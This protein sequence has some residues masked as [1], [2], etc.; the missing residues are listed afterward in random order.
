MVAWND[1]VVGMERRRG[2]AD[3]GAL[4]IASDSVIPR[5]TSLQIWI[6]STK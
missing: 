5:H 1:V 4:C 2:F 3:V 6:S